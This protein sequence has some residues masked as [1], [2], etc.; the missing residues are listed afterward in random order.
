MC[1]SAVLAI[2]LQGYS[3]LL[4]LDEVSH[5]SSIKLEMSF[6]LLSLPLFP[7]FSLCQC[8]PSSS[9][10]LSLL[11]FLPSLPFLAPSHLL[12]FPY[13]LP[14]FLFSCVSISLS[15]ESF[16]LLILSVWPSCH[17]K[18]NIFEEMKSDLILSFLALGLAKG[19]TPVR[20]PGFDDHRTM[21][22]HYLGFQCLSV[23]H[24]GHTFLGESFE[25]HVHC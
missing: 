1:K 21:T 4:G 12:F 24:T 9:T 3:L 13:F 22:Q 19:V 10:F 7:S 25:P 2:S 17:Q 6:V 16:C 20:I 14:H 8:F 5:N 18:I 11:F 15:C 23:L